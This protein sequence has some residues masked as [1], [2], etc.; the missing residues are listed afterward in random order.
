M[1]KIITIMVI[2]VM[3]IYAS[4]LFAL[5]TYVDYYK[6]PHDVNVINP[7]QVSLDIIGSNPPFE[8][9]GH[10]WITDNSGNKKLRIWWDW[11]RGANG[12]DGGA[13]VGDVFLFTGSG[14]Y[15]VALR[16]HDSYENDGISQ[17]DIF[18]VEGV[19]TSDYYFGP[20]TGVVKQ[21]SYVQYGDH[22]IVTAWGNTVGNAGVTWYP[23]TSTSVGNYY[24]DIYFG[25]NSLVSNDPTIR[26]TQ[27][28]ANDVHNPV[29]EPSVL[30]LLGIG[31]IG[32]AMVKRK[33]E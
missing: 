26:L 20:S 17:G 28:C 16:N 27:T 8:I 13:K 18:K 31:L 4:T 32:V 21:V 23:W 29:P 33:H 2:S 9:Y 14:T 15:G 7:N 10:E 22:E 11:N 19:R 25:S 30:I 3:L 1:K 6:H 5:P 12:A 24:T